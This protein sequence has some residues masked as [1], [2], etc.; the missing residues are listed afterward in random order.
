MD[1]GEFFVAHLH[2]ID[3]NFSYWQSIR[4]PT[5]PPSSSRISPNRVQQPTTGIGRRHHLM[6]PKSLRR[7]PTATSMGQITNTSTCMDEERESQRESTGA[8]KQGLEMHGFFMPGEAL[9]GIYFSFHVFIYYSTN[10]YLK[11]N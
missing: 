3:F 6:S 9:K 1:L 10:D 11:L 5:H 7:I 4:R 8:T 2:N